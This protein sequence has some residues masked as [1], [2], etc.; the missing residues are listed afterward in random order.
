VLK[1]MTASEP[2]IP[3]RMQ[4]SPKQEVERYLRTGEQDELSCNWPGDNFLARAQYAD[5]TLR[6]TLISTVRQRTAHAEVPAALAGIDVGAFTRAK[7]APM[8]STSTSFAKPS[9]P[10]MAGRASC[11]AVLRHR[12]SAIVRLER[13]DGFGDFLHPK[14]ERRLLSH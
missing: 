14:G 1:S 10:A 11:S 13:N 3:R 6:D 4:P 12:F 5:A 7:V 2:D 9:P 8:L